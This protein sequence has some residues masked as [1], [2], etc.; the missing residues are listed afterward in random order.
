[1]GR[2]IRDPSSSWEMDVEADMG[3]ARVLVVGE[4]QDLREV[5]EWLSQAG[6]VVVAS[7]ESAAPG[8]GLV[9]VRGVEPLAC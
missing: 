8:Y 7:A 4:D 5:R 6:F 3:R 2:N 9:R 1:M